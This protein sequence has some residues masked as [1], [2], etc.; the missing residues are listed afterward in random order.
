MSENER[1]EIEA[2]AE[3]LQ[4]MYYDD[5]RVNGYNAIIYGDL[6]TGKTYSLRTCRKPVLIHSFDPGGTFVLR[7][8]IDSGDVIADTRFEV[9]DPDM[10]T[11]FKEWD[12]VYHD[13]KR[14]NFFD[15]VGTYVIDSSTTW[16]Q[17]AMYQVLRMQ[18]RAGT[19]RKGAGKAGTGFHGVPHENDW[20]PQMAMLEKAMRD[21]VS[22]PCD[23]ILTGHD[24]SDKDGVSGK[25]FVH[26]MIT[27]KLQK[28]IPLL[29]SEIYHTDT[30]ETSQGL[31]YRFLTRRTGLY[32]ARTRLGKGGELDLYEEQDFKNIL[33]KVG[34]PTEDKP[35]LLNPA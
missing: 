15:Y 13:L 29:F 1:L 3:K 5:P 30:E 8:L 10:P 23:C 16:A 33:R 26:L 7:D 6:G 28:R 31:I 21:F 19:V 35:R 24:D 14:K 20:L 2:E 9:E 11:S 4:K 27:G 12:E 34:L 22:L 18:G 17:C 25:M 32:Q